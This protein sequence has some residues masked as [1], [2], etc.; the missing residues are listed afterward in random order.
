MKENTSKNY[1]LITCFESYCWHIKKLKSDLSNIY[2]AIVFH[3]LYFI[4][5]A[6]LF[7]EAEMVLV[8]REN[9]K[10]FRNDRHKIL[11]YQQLPA[12][13]HEEQLIN[14]P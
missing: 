11:Q 8:Y 5:A 10:V 7:S 6:T 4:T 14:C 12:F 9:C 3:I 13:D 2:T 1:S